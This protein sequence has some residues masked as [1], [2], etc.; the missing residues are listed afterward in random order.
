MSNK[1]YIDT[2]VLSQVAVQ[3]S[4]LQTSIQGITSRI[5]TVLSET[6]RF[7]P[8]QPG[9]IRSISSLRTR[10]EVASDYAGR[11]SRNVRNAINIWEDGEKNLAGIRMMEGSDLFGSS[12]AGTVADALHRAASVTAGAIQGTTQATGNKDSSAWED[13][14]KPWLKKAIGGAGVFGAIGS[15]LWNGFEK[16]TSYDWIKGANDVAKSA[17]SAYTNVQNGN[18]I[19]KS[20]TGLTNYLSSPVNA[21]TWQGKFSEAFSGKFSSTIGKTSTWVFAGIKA[22]VDNAKEYINGSISLDRTVV[23]TVA[24]TGASVLVSAGAT[25]LVTAGLAAAGVASAPVVLVATGAA[26][27]TVGADW[28]TKKITGAICGTEYGIVDGVGHLTGEIWDYGKEKVSQ[29]IETAKDIGKTAYN[30]GKAAITGIK[31]TF[32]GWGKGL[33]GAFA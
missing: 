27:I 28:V 32:A 26:A 4:Q 25:A 14:F 2:E 13:F 18:G 17:W 7:L 31:D 21:T 1:L 10:S 19:F 6:N 3:L 15:V 16:N 22:T 8:N 12:V 24:E 33:L 5:S 30:V 11:L 23:E 29:A 20:M 9:C